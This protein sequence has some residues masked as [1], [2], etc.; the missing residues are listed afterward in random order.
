[1]C[2]CVCVCVCVCESVSDGFER[3]RESTRDNFRGVERRIKVFMM[4]GP[5]HSLTVDWG[6]KTG[7]QESLGEPI[8]GA[9]EIMKLIKP[10]LDILQHCYMESEAVQLSDSLLH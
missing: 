2:V 3:G 5:D 10:A 9:K 4:R 8:T 7:F 6:E 1:M